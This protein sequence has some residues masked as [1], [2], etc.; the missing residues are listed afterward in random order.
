MLYRFDCSHLALFLA[1]NNLTIEFAGLKYA[2]IG[3]L[4]VLN[5]GACAMLIAFGRHVARMTGEG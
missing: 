4:F 5:L 3:L 2:E 1:L